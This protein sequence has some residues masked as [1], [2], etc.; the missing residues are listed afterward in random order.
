[1]QAH[2]RFLEPTLS[3]WRLMLKQHQIDKLY[4]ALVYGVHLT[5]ASLAQSPLMGYAVLAGVSVTVLP[6]VQPLVQPYVQPMVAVIASSGMAVQAEQSIRS[7]L[8]AVEAGLR[9]MAP[10]PESDLSNLGLTREQLRVA[11]YAA[12]KYRAPLS[13]VQQYVALV[14]EKAAVQRIDPI[15][16]LAVMAVESNFKPTA[17]SHVGAKG[18]MQVHLV[19]HKDKF[20]PF[21][22]KHMAYDPATNIQVGIQIL[23]DY[24]RR[25][26]SYEMALKY[27]VGAANH[28][29]DGG[30]A[31][32]VLSE[33]ERIL[34]AAA[35]RI[36][37]AAPLRAP[38]WL[39]A[40]WQAPGKP[41]ET[42][43][44]KADEATKR[45]QEELTGAN[46][47]TVLTPTNQA[48]KSAPFSDGPSPALD[49]PSA[50]AQEDKQS[51]EGRVAIDGLK[52]SLQ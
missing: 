50:P 42:S 4:G 32:K 36:V 1:M 19:A 8:N 39:L 52:L 28:D 21:G 23:K 13:E 30:Y 12:K 15:L 25:T 3:R 2:V 18:L 22:G 10:E 20:E 35:G 27:Y 9:S 51:R 37:P 41:V 48:S 47:S 43:A 29:N 34:A 46:H 33:R 26:S 45:S 49:V 5:R 24:L 16:V 40:K 7:S 11:N 14:F 17:Q 44:D 38:E 31:Y 6:V